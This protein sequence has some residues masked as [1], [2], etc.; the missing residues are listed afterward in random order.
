M[1]KRIPMDGAWFDVGQLVMDPHS[2]TKKV[3]NATAKD[4]LE[5][6][7]DSNMI[8]RIETARDR[9]QVVKAAATAFGDVRKSKVYAEYNTRV[10]DIMEENLSG[11]RDWHE[12]L[13]PEWKTFIEQVKPTMDRVIDRWEKLG[14]RVA[15]VNDGTQHLKLGDGAMVKLADGRIGKYVG[16]ETNENG[17]IVLK[18]EIPDEVSSVRQSKLPGAVTEHIIEPGERFGRP[19]NRM[20]EAF[21]PRIF[22]NKFVEQLRSGD[23]TFRTA[24]DQM[25]ADNNPHLGIPDDKTFG[26]LKDYAEAFAEG[27]ESNISQFMAN[28]EKER[29]WKLSKFEYTDANGKKVIVDPYETSYIDGVAK[30]LDRANA[31]VALAENFGVN[32]KGMSDIITQL[33]KSPETARYAQYAEKLIGRLFNQGPYSAESA[34]GTFSKIEGGYQ[35]DTKLTGGTSLVAQ[36][37]DILIP[38]TSTGGWNVTKS[39]YKLIKDA[40]FR[41]DVD[42]MNGSYQ[43][44]LNDLKEASE[45][46]VPLSIPEKIGIGLEKI[47]T[48][49]ERLDGMAMWRDAVMTAT[50]FKFMDRMVKRINAASMLNEA[51]NILTKFSKAK[52]EIN[53]SSALYRQAHRLGLNKWLTRASESGVDAVL[54]D[55]KF[56]SEFAGTARQYQYSGNPED[57]P[58]WTSTPV[59]SIA[60]RFKK[61][62]FATTK[63]VTNTVLDEAF[64]GNFVPLA[65][66]IGYGMGVGAGTQYLKDLIRGA[67]LDD[68]TRELWEKGDYLQAVQ[69]YFTKPAEENVGGKVYKFVVSNDGSESLMHLVSLGMEALYDSGGTG[70]TGVVSPINKRLETRSFGVD[71]NK[72]FAPISLQTAKRLYDIGNSLNSKERDKAL[73]DAFES[74][75]SEVIP[76][77]RVTDVFNYRPEE[78]RRREM[79]RKVRRDNAEQ[80]PKDLPDKMRRRMLKYVDPEEKTTIRLNKRA[81]RN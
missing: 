32:P 26:T 65:R 10:R 1:V 31:R 77:R 61:P 12:G 25:F 29:T 37:S 6:V 8:R 49:G 79:E 56:Q 63:L 17:K 13:P 11:G 47:G 24:F 81:S 53:P 7:L 74:T 39:I 72:V 30:Y 44:W 16:F 60:M 4:L 28:L 41:N 62:W 45:P 76:F 54:E 52:G 36:L 27:G 19:I 35:A 75:R 33:H 55:P 51:T 15:V 71:I 58:L 20:G 23:K 73:A 40:D 18:V 38:A 9:M 80:V 5:N 67:G 48:P 70:I 14:G 42:L 2:L 21:V 34:L 3:G 66:F 69:R 57:L 59:G 46:G 64:N 78:V 43:G 68:E 22:T 50:G